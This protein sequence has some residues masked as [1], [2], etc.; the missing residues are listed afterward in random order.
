MRSLSSGR[1]FGFKT[2][3][4]QRS[5]PWKQRFGQL[6]L[7]RLEDRL[8]PDSGGG[9]GQFTANLSNLT[10]HGGPL[11]QS[12]QI[13]PIFLMDSGT[14]NGASAAL[15]SSIDA[16]FNAIATD[17]F[18][19]SQLSQYSVP[20]NFSGLGNPAY[21]IG[22]GGKGADDVN[23]L[24]TPDGSVGG[25][26][27]DD[28]QLQTIISD[29]I[30]AGKTASNTANTLYFLFTPPGD[31]VTNASGNSTLGFDGYHTAFWNGSTWIYYAV[32]PDQ[33][34]PGPN[35]NLA[36]FGLTALQGEEQ[37]SSHEMAEAITDPIPGSG[38]IGW[39]NPT[40]GATGEVG[41]LA[42]NESYT[43]DG[44]QVQ[45]LWSNTLVGPGRAPGTAN[46]ANLFINQ[47]TPPAVAATTSVP[48]AT[49]TDTDPTL[50]NDPSKFTAYAISRNGP[51]YS[52]YWPNT[53][54][55]GANGVYVVNATPSPALTVGQVGSL[56]G[57]D[58]MYVFVYKGSKA[59]GNPLA[60]RY[61]PFTVQS[62]APLTYNAENGNL[63]HNFQLVE[64]GSNFELSDNGQLVFVQ[65]IAATTAINI[66]TD[67]GS[68]DSSLTLDYSGGV[69][70]NPVSFDGGAGSGTHTLTWRTPAFR[71]R[72]PSPAQRA[73]AS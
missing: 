56:G 12:V 4:K 73:E 25:R 30:A 27:I 18:I 39:Q 10:Y 68:V 58:G 72:T 51:S 19:P 69:F 7:E 33:S 36:G 1:F 16:F 41:D 8:V 20:A 48:I 23:V 62:S 64:K 13:E 46:Q 32:I 17:S 26:S 70:T 53:I 60:I 28:S 50:A 43:L 15:Q 45:Y 11:I 61:Q 47:L 71:R 44:N 14:G 57:Q 35:N 34:V 29:E 31:A 9:A 6:Y 3:S 22:T 63:A 38:R 66:G 2:S 40:I 5:R 59:S 49:F 42:A 24:V 21:T 52:N 37:V 67:A 55:G 65:P 54:T